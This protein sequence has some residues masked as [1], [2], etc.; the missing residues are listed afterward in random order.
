MA[1]KNYRASSSL[2]KPLVFKTMGEAEAYW[3]K[4]LAGYHKDPDDDLAAMERWL[5]EVV[6]EE[7]EDQEIAE[8]DEEEPDDFFSPSI[9]RLQADAMSRGF[10]NYPPGFD[11]RLLD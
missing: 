7:R 8:D 1:K 9:G 4:N 10:S 6:I 5:N 11:E 2:G 3:E